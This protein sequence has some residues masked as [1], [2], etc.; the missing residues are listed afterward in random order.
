MLEKSDK[1]GEVTIKKII[2]GGAANLDGTLTL[3]DQLLRVDGQ[4]V[5]HLGLEQVSPS[6][7]LT[8]NLVFKC[9]ARED[10]V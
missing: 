3:K 1:S 4:S 8:T 2:A 9:C 6:V 5:Q 7:P 10:K